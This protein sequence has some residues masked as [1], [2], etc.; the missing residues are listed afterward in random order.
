[1]SPANKKIIENVI[2]TLKIMETNY[3]DSANSL[4]II[5]CGSMLDSV[6]QH[7]A[8]LE[9]IDSAPMTTAVEAEEEVTSRLT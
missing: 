9:A 5:F 2:A 7:E 6:L 3:G 1:M 8:A 4:R